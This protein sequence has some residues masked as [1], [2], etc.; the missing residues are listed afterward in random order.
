MEKL[1]KGVYGYD[2]IVPRYNCDMHKVMSLS[3][4][5]KEI[6]RVSTKHSE[7]A[8][9]DHQTLLNMNMVFLLSKVGIKINRMPSVGENIKI[10]TTPQGTKGVSFL[11]KVQLG[12]PEGELLVDCQTSWA[13]LDTREGKI[14]RPK[15][16]PFEFV[17]DENEPDNINV[18]GEKLITTEEA[19]HSYTKVVRYTDL[20]L[21]MHMNNTIY[22]N[23]IMDA[24][25][26]ELLTEKTPK[27]IYLHYRK[28]CK[29]GD[30]VEVLCGE[31]AT[32][33]Y[34]VVGTAEDGVRF[35]SNIYF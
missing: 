4:L 18:L 28:E 2:F 16:F 22:A 25:P 29:C 7:V 34:Y 6:E 20:D 27:K 3:C 33:S 15:A 14:L 8:F 31:I 35:S 1:M 21:N 26:Y 10:T 32:N 11:R 9:A 12:T 19:K 5:M 13:L 17:M 24:L 23:V 30:E